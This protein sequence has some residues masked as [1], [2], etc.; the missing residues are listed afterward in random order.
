MSAKNFEIKFKIASVAYKQKVWKWLE[1]PHVKEFWD[2]SLAHRE[3]IRI[4]MEGRKELSPYW[5]GI[6]DYWIGL[7]ND[8]PY[9]LLMTSEIQSSQSDLP[10][11]WISYLSKSGKTLSIDFMIGNRKY[12][13]CGLGGPT[14]E[15]FTKFV[16]ETIDPSVDTFFIDPADSNSRA[17]H[18]YEKGGFTAVAAFYRDCGEEKNVKHY[19]MVKNLPIQE[20]HKTFSSWT[21]SCGIIP[22]IKS[23]NEW[24]VFLIQHRNYEQYWTCPKGHVEPGETPEMTAVRELKEETGLDVRRFLQK[25]PLIEEFYWVNKGEKQLK[26]ILFFIAEVKGQVHIQDQEIIHGEWVPLLQAAGRIAHLEGKETLK[27]VEQILQAIQ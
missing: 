18:V 23:G 13:G 5:N 24:K 7:V 26:R 19:L 11:V 10:T 25:E 2:N 1:E 9:C 17:K 6:F 20:I 22:L 3:D 15:A 8:E 12:L 14:L 21:G 27:Q 4:F 16:Q